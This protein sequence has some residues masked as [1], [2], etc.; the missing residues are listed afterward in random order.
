ML[1]ESHRV[2]SHLMAQEGQLKD[3]LSATRKDLERQVYGL[4]VPCAPK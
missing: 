2:L 1:K 4:N 3:E